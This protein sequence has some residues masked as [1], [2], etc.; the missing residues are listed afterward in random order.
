MFEE[1][2]RSCGLSI[3]DGLEKESMA[4]ALRLR[5]LCRT[6]LRMVE[7]GNEMMGLLSKGEGRVELWA[8]EFFSRIRVTEVECRMSD[9]DLTKI[10]SRRMGEAVKLLLSEMKETLGTDLPR[11]RTALSVGEFL[12]SKEGGYYGELHLRAKRQLPLK[13]VGIR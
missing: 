4:V 8:P 5:L 6:I 2:S 1:I 7:E 9:R 12:P 3:P 13:P 10:L 11:N